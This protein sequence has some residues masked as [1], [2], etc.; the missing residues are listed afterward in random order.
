MI[1]SFIYLQHFDRCCSLIHTIDDKPVAAFIDHHE[2]P[3]LGDIY[4]GRVVKLETAYAFVDIGISKPALLKRRALTLHEGQY[5]NVRIVREGIKNSYEKKGPQVVLDDTQNDKLSLYSHDNTVACLLRR[6]PKWQQY[7]QDL[8]AKI[9]K[10]KDIAKQSILIIVN[11]EDL[12]IA[13]KQICQN[14]K[15]IIKLQQQSFPDHVKTCWNDLLHEVHTFDEGGYIVMEE[16]AVLTTIDIN[17]TA[18]CDS[19]RPYIILK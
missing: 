12:F 19:D 13:V 1:D 14:E 8:V 16:T 3:R 9:S 18:F 4:R 17:T 6:A 7:I 5:V 15:I 10:D 2:S 11:T